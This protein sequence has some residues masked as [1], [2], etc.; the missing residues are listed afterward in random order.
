MRNNDSLKVAGV[1]FVAVGLFGVYGASAAKPEKVRICHATAS[2]SNPYNSIEVDT[3]AIDG[4]GSNDHSSHSGDIIPPVDG[5]TAGL[6]WTTAGQAI[7]NNDCNPVTVEETSTTV[8][9]T[10]TTVEDTTTTVE[11]TTTT[12]EDTTT[13]TKLGSE[14]PDPETT[15]P[16]TMALDSSGPIPVTGGGDASGGILYLASLLFGLGC[17]VIAIARRPARP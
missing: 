9:E 1:V 7:Y 13:T 2:A 8:E 5:V 3:D 17:L 15:V 10:S 12:V 16:S 4:A 11:D 14:G 6:N